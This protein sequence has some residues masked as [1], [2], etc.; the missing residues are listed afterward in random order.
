MIDLNEW[1]RQ[2]ALD[3]AEKARR[4]LYVL[5]VTLRDLGFDRDGGPVQEAR[6]MISKLLVTTSKIQKSK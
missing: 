1:L 2:Q 3:S 6:E 5:G 4:E